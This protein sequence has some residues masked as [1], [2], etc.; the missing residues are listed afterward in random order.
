M[1]SLESIYIQVTVYRISRLDYVSRNTQTD[2]QTDTHIHTHTKSPA[3]AAAFKEKGAI[4][5]LK[6][7]KWGGMWESLE[8][9]KKAWGK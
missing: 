7:S 5:S 3:V 2:R 9:E 8:G 4:I 1:V 6:E